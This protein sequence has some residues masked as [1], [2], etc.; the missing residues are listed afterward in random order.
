M[1]GPGYVPGMIDYLCIQPPEVVVCP[2]C[3]G[4]ARSVPMGAFTTDGSEVK[5]EECKLCW[6]QRIVYKRVTYERVP[7]SHLEHPARVRDY[8]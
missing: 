3:Y 6:G 2:R 1:A 7:D 5:P 4:R 8:D